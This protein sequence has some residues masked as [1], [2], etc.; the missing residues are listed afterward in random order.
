MYLEQ[1]DH[2]LQLCKNEPNVLDKIE[3]DIDQICDY[4]STIVISETN[5][6]FISLGDDP[7][8]KED[9]DQYKS[10]TEEVSKAVAEL[11]DIFASHGFT[12]LFDGDVRNIFD[13][14]TFARDLSLELYRRRKRPIK[15]ISL[16]FGDDITNVSVDDSNNM[17]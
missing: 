7:V 3:I 15:T 12:P 10:L 8:K 5:D 11:N 6:I 9:E 17:N 1:I 4:F 13:L 14:Q 2:F 16:N